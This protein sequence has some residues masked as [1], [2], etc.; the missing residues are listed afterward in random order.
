M[1][2]HYARVDYYGYTLKNVVEF[3]EDQRHW[4]QIL[5]QNSPKYIRQMA[6][7]W[8]FKVPK[9]HNGYVFG[10]NIENAIYVW[11]NGKD[12]HIEIT[13][14]GCTMLY[15]Q[16]LLLEVIQETSNQ[17]TRIDIAHDIICDV[18]PADFVALS[19]SKTSANGHQN[20]ETGETCYIGSRKSDRYC[21]VY[22]YRLP[23]PR[24]DRLRIEYT[25]KSHDAV[26]CANSLISSNEAIVAF[27]SAARYKWEHDCFK[28]L[29]SPDL[30]EIKAY[31]KDRNTGKTLIWWKNQVLPALEKLVKTGDYTIVDVLE[32]MKGIFGEQHNKLITEILQSVTSS[33]CDNAHAEINLNPSSDGKG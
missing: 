18:S 28:T 1:S 7:L 15:S 32:D 5:T 22:R 14:D 8:D 29:Q 20:S 19:S 16:S 2:D 17:A 33:G 4:F 26:I 27:S 12:I 3:D 11:F 21:K 24:A 6:D 30:I 31:R 23:H 9:R 10:F 13:G 25:Y